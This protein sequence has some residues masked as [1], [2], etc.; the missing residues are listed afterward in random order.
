MKVNNKLIKTRITLIGMLLILAIVFGALLFLRNTGTRIKAAAGVPTLFYGINPTSVRPGQAFDLILRV[1]PNGASF[2]AFELYTI[3]DPTKV[4]FQDM[5]NLAA[6]ISSAYILINSNIDP[7]NNR[8]TIIGAK[9]GSPFSGSANLEI[10]RVKMRVI[11]GAEGDM[12]F[13][14]DGSTKVGNNISRDTQDGTFAIVFVPTATPTPTR[15]P[16]PTPTDVPTPTPT[17]VTSGP[18]GLSFL[19]SLPDVTTSNI[20][21]ADVQI[22]LRDGPNTLGVANVNLIQ[23]NPG[24]YQTGSPVWLDIPEIRP[25]S[26]F[27]KTRIGVGRSFSGVS[28]TPLQELD[29]TVGSNLACGELI[30]QRNNKPLWSG[31]SDGFDTG[32]GSYNKVDSA[33]LSVLTTYYNQPGSGAAAAADFNFDGQVDISDLEILGKNYTRVGD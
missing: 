15:T 25:F 1:N 29:C 27:V 32:S 13:S 17:P 5:N 31:D 30:S 2:N 12:V 20:S 6:N 14:W 26:V 11:S 24:F 8:I 22:E 7:T 28:L 18:S 21:L 9:T 10:A 19:L 4:E 16:A 33:D 3:Y 23:Q